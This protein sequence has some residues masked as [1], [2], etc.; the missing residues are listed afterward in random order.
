MMWINMWHVKLEANVSGRKFV[1][2]FDGLHPFFFY[3]NT[4]FFFKDIPTHMSL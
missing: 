4:F 1:P 3:F 2:L